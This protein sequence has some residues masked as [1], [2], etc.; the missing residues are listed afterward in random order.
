MTLCMALHTDT[1]RLLCP[2]LRLLQT[3]YRVLQDNELDAL[4][5]LIQLAVVFGPQDSVSDL[6]EVVIERNYLLGAV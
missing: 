2:Q 6:V 5:A 4:S 1:L 3:C